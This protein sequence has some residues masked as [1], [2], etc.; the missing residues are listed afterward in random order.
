LPEIVDKRGLSYAWFAANENRMA[1]TLQNVA[2][3]LIEEAPLDLSVVDPPRTCTSCSLRALTLGDYLVDPDWSGYT[4][5]LD[6]G[7][8]SKLKLPMDK[9]AYRF[10]YKDGVG[11]GELLYSG[12]DVWC[13][14]HYVGSSD[15]TRSTNF[16][17]YDNAGINPHTHAELRAA[18]RQC[19]V[20]LADCR[21]NC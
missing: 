8:W 12:G 9:L 1:S 19:S 21:D 2:P 18:N 4:L 14:A 20:G 3:T 15:C 6:G 7:T 16:A 17:H 10:G 5:Q 11:M 13:S